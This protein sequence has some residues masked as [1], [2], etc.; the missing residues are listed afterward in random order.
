[1]S[2]LKAPTY[3]NRQAITPRWRNEPTFGPLWSDSH[4]LA[5][6]NFDQSWQRNDWGRFLQ[7]HA[8]AG[9]FHVQAQVKTHWFH[10]SMMLARLTL[11]KGDKIFTA[12]P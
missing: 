3:E 8:L 7:E 12:F 6:L 11:R 2:D 4:Q 5:K 1:M 10:D 9:V